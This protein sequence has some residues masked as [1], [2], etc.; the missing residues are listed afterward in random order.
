MEAGLS[1][2]KFKLL[3]NV[4]N[5]LTKGQIKSEAKENVTFLSLSW[6]N[7]DLGLLQIT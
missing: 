7:S 2:D 6:I 3:R 5:H 4:V 1:K